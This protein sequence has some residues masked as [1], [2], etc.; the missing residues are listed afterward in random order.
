[1]FKCLVIENCTYFESTGP[2]FKKK[3][4]AGQGWVGTGYVHFNSKQVYKCNLFY[5]SLL[6]PDHHLVLS[7]MAHTQVISGRHGKKINQSHKNVKE[8]NHLIFKKATYRHP[9]YGF[10]K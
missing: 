3:K 4:K 6:E 7:R 8:Q 2:H 5:F 1:M 10:K 9:L